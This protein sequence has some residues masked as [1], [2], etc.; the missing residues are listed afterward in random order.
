MLISDLI[1]Q[2]WK[3]NLRS[4]GFYKSLSVKILMIFMGTYMASIFL[5]LGLFLGDI[6]EETND[7]LTPLEVFNGAM[8]YI[9]IGLLT[10]RFF[11]QQLNTLNL[12]SY[13]T[14]P[15]K[16]S[17]LVH[18]LLLKPI[19][20][21]TNYLTLLIVI[22]FAIKSVYAYYSGVVALQ[23]ILNCIF[24]IWFNVWIATYLKRKFGSSLIALV[25]ILLVSGGLALLEYLKIFSLFDF[26]LK[27]FNPLVL[28]PFG[29]VASLIAA[30]SAYGLNVLFFSKNY[31]PEKFNEKLDRGEN[32]VIGGF[33]LLERYGI[34]GELMQLQ[35]RLIIRHKRTKS[36]VIMSGFML[37][38]GLLFYTNP[39]YKDSYGWL[40][41][42]AIFTTGILMIMYGQWIISWE[43][44][45]F[46]SLL[47]KNIP[48][49]TYM[50]AN[51]FLLLAFNLASFILTTPYFFF[52]PQIIFLHL[53]AFL[54]NTG[55][56]IFIFLYFA[57]Y[58]TKRVDLNAR[59]SF[60]Y[61]GTTYKSF[62]IVLPIL[63][64]PM[65]V[66]SLFSA[67]GYINGGLIFLGALGLLGI[68][69]RESLLKLCTK[70]F[71]KRK[72]TMA[73]GFREKG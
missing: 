58:N 25:V 40:F 26:S 30:I 5:M 51:F 54:Y 9:L 53:S 31:Y 18:F 72:Y 34:I 32:K 60:N 73:R 19:F 55:V 20:S 50:R 2:D 44:G 69:F 45:Y 17:T 68:I 35:I 16:R 47:T 21:V 7:T 71:V 1:K 42:S 8:L 48:A 23:F 4:Q 28:N 29:F 56:N 65:I 6:L 15:V 52:G 38:Y 22:P 64:F 27:V 61:Q 10:V 14:L 49:I 63:F 24:L 41:F 70:Q 13:Q 57:S 12:Q 39:V 37:L 59:S 11:M 36:L 67:I 33:S 46:D 3:K 43:S 62:L 66:M